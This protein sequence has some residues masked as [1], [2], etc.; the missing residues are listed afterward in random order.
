MPEMTD[1]LIRSGFQ[2]VG[3]GLLMVSSLACYQS[4]DDDDGASDGTGSYCPLEEPDCEC[5]LPEELFPFDPFFP[6]FTLERVSG[7]TGSFG[8]FRLQFT[9]EVEQ[10]I[11]FDH[12]QS[13]CGGWLGIP[14]E[15]HLIVGSGMSKPSG[16][17]TYSFTPGPVQIV[18]LPDFIVQPGDK[19]IVNPL[20]FRFPELRKLVPGIQYHFEFSAR[21]WPPSIAVSPY[22]IRAP[23]EGNSTPWV[24]RQGDY[25]LL[26]NAG[27]NNGVSCMFYDIWVGDTVRVC[28][29][30]D[31]WVY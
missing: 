28:D 16:N 5:G 22:F 6:T 11:D 23:Y 1:V 30:E 9:L 4:D 25:Y 18:D 7:E 27:M 31:Y 14:M 19:V 17:Y 8:P 24:G 21:E 29:K 20:G 15:L 13:E 26:P 2:F 3:V 12:N 10:E